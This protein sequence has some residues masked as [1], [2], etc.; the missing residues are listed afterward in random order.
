MTDTSHY[1]WLNHSRKGW[2]QSFKDAVRTA[3]ELTLEDVLP[4]PLCVGN[5]PFM[6]L[7]SPSA[8][9]GWAGPGP[10]W[11]GWAQP[12]PPGST[13]A[14]L[15][16]AGQERPRGQSCLKINSELHHFFFL[17]C[18]T[19]TSILQT[20]LS[21]L[22]NIP[23]PCSRF[24]VLPLCAAQLLSSPHPRRQRNCLRT[25]GSSRIARS[26]HLLHFRALHRCI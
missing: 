8:H 16:R 3:I 13:W 23:A 25:P 4:L 19:L 9:S 14:R 18:F 2:L 20:V 21:G 1:T 5:A 24:L 10:A 17:L 6:M 22:Q 12:V 26:C 11:G 7:P 15:T